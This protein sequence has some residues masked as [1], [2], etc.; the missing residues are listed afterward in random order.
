[1]LTSLRRLIRKSTTIAN[2]EVLKGITAMA[3]KEGEV[4]DM[5]IHIRGSHLQ[6]GNIVKRRSP[7]LLTR[8][9][10]SHLVMNKVG[11]SN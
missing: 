3:V 8:S 9:K 7:R 5:P 1:M 6:T 11:G 10:A 2:G 4:T